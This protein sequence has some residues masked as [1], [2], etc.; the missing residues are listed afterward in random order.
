MWASYL[1]VYKPSFSEVWITY[2]IAINNLPQISTS[3]LKKQTRQLASNGCAAIF[4]LYR[5]WPRQTQALAR[6]PD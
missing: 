3:Y 4:H 6:L 1:T 2:F 5:D